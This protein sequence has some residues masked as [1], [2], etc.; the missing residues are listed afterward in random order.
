MAVAAL[1]IAG[2][3][4]LGKMTNTQRPSSTRWSR[5][6]IVQGDIVA[7]SVRGNFPAKYFS[8][9]QRS[10]S[11]FHRWDGESMLLETPEGKVPE[12]FVAKS[13][14]ALKMVGFQGE[15]AAGN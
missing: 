1:F 9:R 5:T 2:C 13:S 12:N 3:S 7:V 6:S 10:N 15:G 4:G 8:R 14:T 11:P